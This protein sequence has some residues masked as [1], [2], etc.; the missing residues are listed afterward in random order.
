MKVQ[1]QSLETHPDW[2]FS[3]EII[4][5][6]SQKGYMAYLAGG[7]VRD[8]VLGR[9]AHDLDVATSARPEEVE[10]IFSKTVSVGKSFGVIR[11]LNPVNPTQEVEVATFREDGAYKDGRR[12]ENVIFSSPERDAA[13]RDLTINALFYDTQ[14]N[15]ILDFVGGLQDIQR[16]TIRTVGLPEARFQEDHL[17]ILRAARFAIEFEFEIESHT[18]IQ[19]QNLAHLLGDVSRERV[20]EELEKIWQGSHPQKGLELIYQMQLLAVIDAEVASR[21]DQINLK[22]F[23]KWQSEYQLA[24]DCGA[25]I[26]WVLFFESLSLEILSEH[27]KKYRFSNEEKKSILK[28]MR[29]LKLNYDEQSLGYILTQYLDSHFQWA[30]KILQDRGL[31]HKV[32]LKLQAA[33]EPS[34]KQKWPEPLWTGALIPEWIFP[35]QR[36]EFL[37]KTY[38]MQLEFRWKSLDDFKA[39]LEDCQRQGKYGQRKSL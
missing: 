23:S 36:G 1:P 8:L 17:R 25:Q 18:K 31:F 15:Q 22:D 7:C 6:L 39:W 9:Q 3:L 5:K 34:W 29:L 2:V 10:K 38:E 4:K 27:L 16:K 13:R 37:K 20:Q 32:W 26:P 30:Q 33:V 35:D 24:Q 19:M 12:P 21:F 28:I 11:V 14:N